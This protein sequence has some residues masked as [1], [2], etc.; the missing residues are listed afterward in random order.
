MVGYHGNQKTKNA[1]KYKESTTQKLLGIKLK[2]CRIVSNNSLYK[3]R[4]F[5]FFFFF[6]FFLPL[7][8]HFGCYGKLKFPLT[9]NGKS[10]N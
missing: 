3:K 6:F 10:E 9:Y 5:F 4:F 8:R 7:L 2:L 1:K